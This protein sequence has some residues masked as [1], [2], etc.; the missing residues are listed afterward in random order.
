MPNKAR[1][2]CERR[3]DGEAVVSRE[4][5]TGGLFRLLLESFAIEF[6]FSGKP[7]HK[8]LDGKMG[9]TGRF[10]LRAFP[11]SPVD[12]LLRGQ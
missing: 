7:C 11:I 12:T 4:N 3:R 5:A 1:H 8:L 10:L 2:A 6:G 9:I